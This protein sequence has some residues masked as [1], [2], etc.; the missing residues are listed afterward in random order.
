MM[1]TDLFGSSV[2][3]QD[4]GDNVGS[5]LRVEREAYDVVAMGEHDVL[6]TGTG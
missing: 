3:G 5:C 1:H 6:Q 2:F 4:C